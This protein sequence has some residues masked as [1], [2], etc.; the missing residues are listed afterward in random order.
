MNKALRQISKSPFTRRI[1]GAKLPHRFAQPA[2]TIYNGRLD[3]VEH[4][5]HFN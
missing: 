3:P 4:V 5:S 2:F 1:E